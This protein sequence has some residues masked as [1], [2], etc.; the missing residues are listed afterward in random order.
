MGFWVVRGLAYRTFRKL[1]GVA[2]RTISVGGNSGLDH[3]GI[4]VVGGRAC[5]C[6]WVESGVACTGFWVVGGGQAFLKYGCQWLLLMLLMSSEVV[7][8][9]LRMMRM[10]KAIGCG[11]GPQWP[12]REVGKARSWV[13]GHSLVAIIRLVKVSR[14]SECVLVVLFS[15]QIHNLCNI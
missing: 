13:G 4:L 10:M 9:L 11:R 14:A 2:C 7:K 6:F 3:W 5:K 8:A 15:I 1:R 12:V